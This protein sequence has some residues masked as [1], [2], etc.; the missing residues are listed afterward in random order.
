M[1][2]G[3]VAGSQFIGGRYVEGTSGETDDVT[4]PSTGEVVA[5]VS[6]AAARSGSG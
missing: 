5:T 4:D 6:L 1:V 2:E 3:R